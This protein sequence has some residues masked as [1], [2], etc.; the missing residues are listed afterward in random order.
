M[1]NVF[2][3]GKLGADFGESF[4]FD[5]DTAAEAVRALNCAFPGDNPAYWG[6]EA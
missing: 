4:R 6:N 2:L 3:Y 5:I 1:R